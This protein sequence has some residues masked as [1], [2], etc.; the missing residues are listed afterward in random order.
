MIGI[1]IVFLSFFVGVSVGSL[2]EATLIV[3]FFIKY[4]LP[5]IATSV[6]VNDFETPVIR[7]LV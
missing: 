7:I 5:A 3:D 2:S 6:Y 1:L 4:L